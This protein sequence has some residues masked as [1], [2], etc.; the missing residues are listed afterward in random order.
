MKLAFIDSDVLL[1]VILN[2]PTFYSASAQILSL[3]IGSGYN[4]CTAVHTLINVHYFTKKYLG[5]E[6]AI[7]AIKLLSKQLRVLGEDATTI[8]DAIASDFKDFEDAVQYFAAKNA[9]V[10]LIITRN[11]KDY[12]NS[13]IP[14][15][16]AEQFLNT[17]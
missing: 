12:K 9:G 7:E 13:T 1:D 3:S 11:I 14:V 17:L 15:L 5:A 10:D 2:R 16:T 6:T 4:F 8:N